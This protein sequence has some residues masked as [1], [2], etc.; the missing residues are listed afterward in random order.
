MKTQSA[1]NFRKLGNEYQAI[2]RLIN[3]GKVVGYYWQGTKLVSKRIPLE[4]NKL[5]Q[6]EKRA[7]WL[8]RYFGQVKELYPSGRLK[9][10]AIATVSEEG[11]FRYLPISKTGLKP[12]Q[13]T[14]IRRG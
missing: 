12:Y 6:L 1:P 9:E 2:N 13:I 4:P 14:Q 11:E 10:P 5:A 7:E 3:D 8:M